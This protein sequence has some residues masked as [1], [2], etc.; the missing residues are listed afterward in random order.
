[1]GLDTRVTDLPV[2]Q[3]SRPIRSKAEEKRKALPFSTGKTGQ[4]AF[5]FNVAGWHQPD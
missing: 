5:H 4:L 3:I 1:M 2:G